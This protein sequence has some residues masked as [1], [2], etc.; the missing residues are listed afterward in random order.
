MRAQRIFIRPLLE[1]EQPERVLAIDMNGMRDAAWFLAR[2]F[3]V[4]EAQPQDVVNESG[5]ARMLPVTMIM[6]NT[7]IVGQSR[8]SF[9]RCHQPHHRPQAQ[10]MHCVSVTV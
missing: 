1:E 10:R 4:L 9:L 2:T 5:R 3:D 6:F 7:P 8:P